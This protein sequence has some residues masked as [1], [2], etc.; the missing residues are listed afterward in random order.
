V[1]VSFHSTPVV[2]GSVATDDQGRFSMTVEVPPDASSGQ[3]HF[4]ARGPTS[5][6][7]ITTLMAAVSVTVPTHHHSWVL[8]IAMVALTLILAAL[9]ALVFTRS[10]GRLGSLLPPR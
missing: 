7:A 8:P 6:G 10:S 4:E 3:H 9:A 2:I 5:A 1:T